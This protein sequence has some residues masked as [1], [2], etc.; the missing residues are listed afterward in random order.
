VVSID[1]YRTA[2]QSFQFGR[3]SAMAVIVFVICLLMSYVYRRLLETND[4]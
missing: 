4:Q 1:I 2:F 3:A